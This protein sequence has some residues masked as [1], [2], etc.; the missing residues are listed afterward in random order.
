MHRT[1]GIHRERPH[2]WPMKSL[3]FVLT[4]FVASTSFADQRLARLCSDT[5][6]ALNGHALSLSLIVTDVALELTALPK[7]KV[8]TARAAIE[9]VNVAGAI[10]FEELSFLGVHIILRNGGAKIK[11]KVIIIFLL[12]S[13]NDLESYYTLARML[14]GKVIRD[15]KKRDTILKKMDKNYAIFGSIADAATKMIRKRLLK[16]PK[17][18]KEKI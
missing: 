17:G 13:I 14:P 1:Q 16:V 2:G 10:V 6:L 15:K 8:A 18:R 5:A 12:N 4:F 3:A 9:A 7:A 11:D